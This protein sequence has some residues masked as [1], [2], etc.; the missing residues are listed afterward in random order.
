[1]R[2]RRNSLGAFGRGV[3]AGPGLETMFQRHQFDGLGQEVVHAGVNAGAAV[4]FIG[5]GGQ[6]DNRCA[7][8]HGTDFASRTDAIDTGQAEIHE[9]DIELAA[10][11]NVDG[12]FAR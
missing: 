1:M 11:Q 9:N 5:I 3:F 4:F 6:G 2:L 12:F 7:D 10:F 8:T